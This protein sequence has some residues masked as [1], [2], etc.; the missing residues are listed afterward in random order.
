MM[1]AARLV[2]TMI[3]PLALTSCF[4]V[5][6]A[7]ISSLD[8]R[9]GGDFTFAYKG[10]VVF[11]SPEDMVPGKSSAKQSWADMK[12]VCPK[13][14]EPYY[15]AYAETT[16][17]VTPAADAAGSSTETTEVE[18]SP[19]RSCKSAE[20]AKVKKDWEEAQ[21][22]KQAKDKKD[23]E[24]FAAMFG[25]NPTDDAANRK[26][27]T[28]LMRYDG[29]KSVVYRGKGVFDVDYQLSGKVGHDYVFP[30]FPQGDVLIPF[31]MIRG[32]DKGSVRVRAPALIG[33]GMKALAAQAKMLG[34]PSEKDMPESTRTKGTFTI[35]TDGEILTNN[36]S[37]GPSKVAGGRSLTWDID[38]SSEQ[39]PE[40]LIKLR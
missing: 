39:I 10:E 35:T 33:G 2:A 25:F 40:A 29:W 8:L 19:N 37:D 36:T 34:A 15:S 20:I 1:K 32:Q 4:L 11:Q 23:G 17:V 3:L 31:V 16:D 38:P 22:A 28:A 5:P 9:K 7:F 13:D 30:I 18:E 24:Q 27:A 26:L 14:G 12:V 21:I 6:G